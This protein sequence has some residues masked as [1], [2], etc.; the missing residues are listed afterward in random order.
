MLLYVSIRNDI[1]LLWEWKSLDEI[2]TIGVKIQ[3]NIHLNIQSNIDAENA[4]RGN[5]TYIL[6]WN[7]Y[8]DS[9][10]LYHV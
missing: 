8:S 1:K 4:L 7:R 10:E 3:P 6:V 9:N 5:E 2:T